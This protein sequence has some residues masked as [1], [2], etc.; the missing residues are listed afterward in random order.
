MNDL[1][2]ELWVHAHVQLAL[3][4][5]RLA[6]HVSARRADE[7]GQTTAEYALVLLGAGMVAM[8]VILWAKKTDRIGKLL[9]A[10]IGSVTDKAKS[11]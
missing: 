8:L 11:E 5:E 7:R 9:D 3:A 6:D 4:G 1:L 10:V 2:L